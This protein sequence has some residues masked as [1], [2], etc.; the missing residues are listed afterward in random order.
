MEREPL[1]THIDPLWLEGLY[2]RAEEK[3]CE[4]ACE[5]LLGVKEMVDNAQYTEI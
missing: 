3:G 2:S 1:L 5:L 4:M